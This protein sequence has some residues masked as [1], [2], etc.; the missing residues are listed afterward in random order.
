VNRGPGSARA[1]VGLGANLGDAQQTLREAVRALADLPQTR[2]V[3]A[4]GCYRS[5]PVDAPGPEFLNA[6]V[7]LRTRLA[8]VRLLQELQRIELAHGRE[9][10]FANAPRTLDLDLLLYGEVSIDEPRLVVPHPR[11]HRRA[12][13]LLPLLELDAQA[14]IPGIGS[15]QAC[16]RAVRDQPVERI[17]ELQPG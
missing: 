4:S 12:F 8:P 9:R 5:A 10:P 13:V 2:F 6:V 3:A 16:L 14:H 1:F 7:E 17:G 15:A 11:M